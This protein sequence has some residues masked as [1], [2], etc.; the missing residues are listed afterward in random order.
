MTERNRFQNQTLNSEDYEIVENG[1]KVLRK[2][3]ELFS[4][5][6]LVIGTGIKYG[7]DLLKRFGENR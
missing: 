4:V 7:S 3:V 5:A 6:V 1:A 2:G